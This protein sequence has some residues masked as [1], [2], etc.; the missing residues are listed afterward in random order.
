MPFRLSRKLR[1][2]P[3]EQQG[4]G[5][6]PS[7]AN[8]FTWWLD[9]YQDNMKSGHGR[10]AGSFT[11][12]IRTTMRDW[13]KAR[14]LSWYS[15]ITFEYRLSRHKKITVTMNRARIYH[16]P[17]RGAGSKG[18]MLDG[19]ILSINGLP[20]SRRNQ[21]GEFAMNKIIGHDSLRM[22]TEGPS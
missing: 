15:Q 10:G 5:G 19:V 2:G 6:E 21:L 3:L 20:P 12:G 17:I 16:R 13:L 14:G 18:F 8:E 4:R 9:L 1:A 11:E 7:L 22:L